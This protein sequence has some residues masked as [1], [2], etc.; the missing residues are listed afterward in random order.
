MPEE[1]VTAVVETPVDAGTDPTPVEPSEPVASPEVKVEPAKV[2]TVDTAKL[3]D[4]VNNLNVALKQER[5]SKKTNFEAVKAMEDKL[6]EA[7]G[8]ITRLGEVFKPEQPQVEE[9]PAGLTESQLEDFWVRKEDERERK[10]K[11]QTQA[12]MIRTEIKTM[13]ETWSGEEGK[14][15]YDDNE[16]V[17]WQKE[18]SKLHLTPKAAFLE[19]KH[20][21]IVDFEVKQRLAKKP[22][23]QNVEKPGG[24]PEGREPAETKPQTM[25]ETRA[26]VMEAMVTADAENNN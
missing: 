9:T 14:P 20:E 10:Q 23:V 3:Q 4:Q 1:Q 2:E 18:N 5:E 22:A 25:L 11:E 17:N 21:D 12:E 15:K 26:A 16:V 24:T 19:M 7:Q 6:E 13:E 8:T